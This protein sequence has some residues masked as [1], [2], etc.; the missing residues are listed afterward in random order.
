MFLISEIMKIAMIQIHPYHYK[1]FWFR[2]KPFEVTLAYPSFFKVNTAFIE[3]T[4]ANS[5][6]PH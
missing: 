4:Y 2:I 3:H 6:A 5:H 1:G